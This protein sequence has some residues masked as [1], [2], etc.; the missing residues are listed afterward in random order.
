M[1][2]DVGLYIFEYTNMEELKDFVELLARRKTPGMVIAGNDHGNDDLTIFSVECPCVFFEGAPP[3]PVL[4][5]LCDY[6]GA[7]DFIEKAPKKPGAYLVLSS[8]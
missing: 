7:L 2:E 1:S 3:M 5:F 4:D 6:A 8:K